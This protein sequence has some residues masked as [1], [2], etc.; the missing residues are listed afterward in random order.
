MLPGGVGEGRERHQDALHSNAR[1]YTTDLDTATATDPPPRSPQAALAW[2]GAL[3]GG[4][5]PILRREG[6]AGVRHAGLFAQALLPRQAVVL[7]PF[8]VGHDE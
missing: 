2:L 4:S 7:I 5:S 8:E 6:R 3:R 1:C